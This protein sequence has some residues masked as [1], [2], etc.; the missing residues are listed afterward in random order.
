MKDETFEVLFI[1]MYAP[2]DTVPHAGGKVHNFYVKELQKREH[3]HQKLISMC[4]QKEVKLLDLDE[5]GI[6]NDIVV[7]DKNLGEKYFRKIVGF[8]SYA[9]VFDKY[10]NTL[11]T[12]ERYQLKR[13]I[14]K[15]K[16]NNGEPDIIILQW[17]QIIFLISYI[18]RLFPNAMIVGIEE[19]VLFLNFYRRID[20]QNRILKR[21]LARYQYK[22]VKELELN[23]LR[24]TDLVVTNNFKD[25]NL[26]IENGIEKEKIYTSAVYFTDYSNVKNSPKGKDILFYGAMN[27]PENYLS[28]KWFVDNVFNH[29]KDTEI[30]FFIVGGNPPKEIKEL[31]S[32]RIIVTG[33]V[34]SVAPYFENCMCMVAPLVLGAGIKVKV[35]E[36]MSAGIPVLTNDIGI[37]GIKAISGIHYFHCKESKEYIEVIQN[38]SS[39]E[40]SSSKMKDESKKFIKENYD[41]KECVN[42]L[43]DKLFVNQ[44]N[45]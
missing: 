21:M 40:Y 9:S 25:S 18:K 30:R 28:V 35:L 45:V 37:E 5:Y 16:V 43:Y 32:D 4:Y 15:Y 27:R 17:T 42:N 6:D 23:S 11:P 2:Y 44:M 3:V 26:L 20:L 12:Y 8:F 41:I 22:K 13:K 14:K 10:G 1:S 24:Q 31:Q 39:K 29:L 33:F 34:D 19:D 38:L 7:L 36:A